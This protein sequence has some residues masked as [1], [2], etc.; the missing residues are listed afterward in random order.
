VTELTKNF[1]VSQV[2]TAPSPAASG[3]SLVVASGHGGRFLT[4]GFLPDGMESPFA[5]DD[6]RRTAWERYGPELTAKYEAYARGFRPSA[7][8][9]SE[10][11]RPQYLGQCPSMHDADLTERTRWSHEANVE[12][13]TWLAKNGHLTPAERAWIAERGREARKRIGTPGEHKAALS[14]DFGGDRLRV[15]IAKAVEAAG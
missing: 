5:S 4:L 6:E 14:P 1:A 15:A 8:W 10:A 3:T 11:G 2:A 7:W 12:K 9:R 13:F